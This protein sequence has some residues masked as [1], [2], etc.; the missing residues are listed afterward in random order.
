[1]DGIKTKKRKLNSGNAPGKFQIPRDT[2]GNALPISVPSGKICRLKPEEW[3]GVWIREA[4]GTLPKE[5]DCSICGEYFLPREIY[6]LDRQLM[7]PN[8]QRQVLNTTLL[9][10]RVCRECKA[11]C[12][13]CRKIVPRAQKKRANDMCQ[14]C[15]DEEGLAPK[16]RRR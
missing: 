8:I 1:M 11:H 14:I 6:P 13:Q 10:T 12:S 5:V 7:H 15:A 2:L 4:L 16:A 9:D 3:E